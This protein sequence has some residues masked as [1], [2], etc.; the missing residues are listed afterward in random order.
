MKRHTIFS[1]FFITLIIYSNIHTTLPESC[2]IQCKPGDFYEKELAINDKL[3]R[4]SAAELQEILG[5]HYASIPSI[6]AQELLNSLKTD[7]DTVV[8]NVLPKH[9]YDDCHIIGSHSVPLKELVCAAQEWPRDRK[10]IVYCALDVCDAGQ[11]AY[12]LLS[13]MGFTHVVDYEGGIKEWFQLGYPTQGPAL[14]SYL[15]ASAKL[16]K[17]ELLK[18]I[19]EYCGVEVPRDR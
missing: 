16:P 7:H 4:I 11:K 19:R 6:S 9:L 3:Y 17:S 2:A 5:V 8:I 15:H 13:C 1:L 10:I 14:S 12:I 18:D